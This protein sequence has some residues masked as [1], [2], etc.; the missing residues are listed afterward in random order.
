METLNGKEIM[1]RPVK[2]NVNTPKRG[3]DRSEGARPATL[4]YDHSWRPQATP[5]RTLQ[6]D[7]GSPHVFD[8]RQRKD[9][10]GHFKGR[11]EGCRLYVGGLPRIPDQETVTE[12]MHALF[13][14]YEM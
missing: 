8:R 12:E 1:G 13:K 9:A 7:N 3:K 11:S 4:S 2:I 14:N 6:E 10:A 5:A